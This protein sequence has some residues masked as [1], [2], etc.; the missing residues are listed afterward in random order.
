MAIDVKKMKAKLD[1]LTN[2]G[3]SSSKTAFWSPKEGNTYSVRIVATPDGDPFKEYWFHYELGTQGGFLCPKKNFGDSC[4]AC[5]FASKLY[6][7]KTEESA[8]MGKKFLPRQRFFSPIV[9]RG[10]EKDGV[11]VWGYGKTVYQ[12]LI[13]LVLNPDY[14]DI[15]DSETGTDLGLAV[16]KAPGQSFPM[17]KL[18]PA[19][20]TS[21]LCQGSPDECKDLLESVPDFDTLHTRKTTDEVATILDQYLASADSDEEAES[22][23]KETKKFGAAPVATKKVATAKPK[24]DIDAAFEDIM[25]A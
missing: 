12:D 15:T 3:G 7:E 16:S 18:T 8:K 4:P 14:G 13:N 2:K 6:R 5:D 11:K 1:A 22:Q 17:T 23:S 10:E 20:K 25:D 19:R 21:K 9:V 24:N